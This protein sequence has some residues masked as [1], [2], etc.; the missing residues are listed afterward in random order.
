MNI[1]TQISQ[2]TRITLMTVSKKS[3]GRGYVYR[4]KLT[5]RDKASGSIFS[6]PASLKASLFP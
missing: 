4:E 5:R 1:N 2:I 3:S 6:P